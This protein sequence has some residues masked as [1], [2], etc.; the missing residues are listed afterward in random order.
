MENTKQYNEKL[1][2]LLGIYKEGREA[3]NEVSFVIYKNGTAEQMAY[4]LG[5]NSKAHH[6]ELSDEQ[7]INY[8]KYEIEERKLD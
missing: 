3:G 8:L 2:K 4:M 6:Y 1:T 7:V 5:V